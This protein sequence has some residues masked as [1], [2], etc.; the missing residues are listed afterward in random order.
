MSQDSLL[1]VMTVSVAVSAIAMVAMAV[2]IFGMWKTLRT[3]RDRVNAFLPRAE[4]FI[5]TTQAT[6]D[7]HTATIRE[8]AGKTNAVLDATQRQLA[9]VDGV[10]AEAA[11]RARVQFDRLELVLDDTV[12]RL[13]STVVQINNSVAKPVKEIN[14]LGTGIR[15]AVQTFLRGQ[16]PSPAQATSDEEMFI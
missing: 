10:V 1:V 2:M 9:R 8:I 6:L 7:E 15:A 4:S 14:A 13:H 3:L 12:G 5:T 16:K 11:A